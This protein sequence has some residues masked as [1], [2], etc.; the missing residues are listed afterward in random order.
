MSA[1]RGANNLIP[2]IGPLLRV[3]LAQVLVEVTALVGWLA[4][5]SDEN[6]LK[7][8]EEATIMVK[9]VC[10]LCMLIT[11]FTRALNQL[12]IIM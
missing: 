12:S 3:V 11:A 2:G 4:S 6:A 10:L 5:S 8:G 7:I 1:Q 9:L